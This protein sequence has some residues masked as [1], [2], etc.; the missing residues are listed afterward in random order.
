MGHDEGE[1]SHA[2]RLTLARRED[3]LYHSHDRLEPP[4]DFGIFGL[5]RLLGPQSNLQL[6]V[7][8]LRSELADPL[9]QRLDL[10]LSAF[11][12]GSLGLAV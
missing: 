8:L 4:L 6:L 3:W 10:Q 1:L 11:S 2:G 9:L 7:R 5:Y 12:N